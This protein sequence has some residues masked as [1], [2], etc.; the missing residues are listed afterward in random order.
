[1]HITPDSPFFMLL[2]LTLPLPDTPET[3]VIS[4]LLSSHCFSNVDWLEEET[5]YFISSKQVR[6]CTAELTSPPF[7]LRILCLSSLLISPRPIDC[8]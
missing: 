8:N 3:K 5:E 2:N 1:M 7:A 4:P 6:D